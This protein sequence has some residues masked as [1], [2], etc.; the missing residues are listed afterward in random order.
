MLPGKGWRR[1]RGVLPRGYRW[2]V[3][4]VNQKNKNGRVMG[5]MVVEKRK[6]CTTG[7][8]RKER[9]E[10]KKGLILENVKMGGE[11]W[12]LWDGKKTINSLEVGW[13]ILNG[14]MEGDGIRWRN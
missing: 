11:S 7:K 5:G 2:Q 13:L 1:V 4:D 12:K 3:E 6:E 14:N 10:E 9:N 8:D